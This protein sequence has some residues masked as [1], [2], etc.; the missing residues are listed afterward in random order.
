[1]W[2]PLCRGERGWSSSAQHEPTTPFPFPPSLFRSLHL[3]H[4]FLLPFLLAPP[5]PRPASHALPVS[6]CF[7]TARAATGQKVGIVGRTGAGKS[8]LMVA[9]FRLFELEP[10]TARPSPPASTG[11]GGGP[12]DEKARAG[13]DDGRGGGGEG[14][15]ESGI[16]IDGVNIREVALQTLRSRLGLITQ[17]PTVFGGT[18]R[19]NLD[20]F[21]SHS[22][23]E[24]RAAAATPRAVLLAE[25]RSGREREGGKEG[26]RAGESERAGLRSVVSA[27]QP[28]RATPALVRCPLV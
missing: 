24:V 12:G 16:Y 22:D 18:V 4:S 17:E 23:D 14:G 27:R 15:R 2:R 7:P 6:A 3:F 8:S 11:E 13:V 20:P 21:G 10:P 28:Q 19:S 5:S 26:R 9:L 25:R 1:M